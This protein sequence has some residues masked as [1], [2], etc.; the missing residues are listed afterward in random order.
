MSS[1]DHNVGDEEEYKHSCV[2]FL[3]K[4]GIWRKYGGNGLMGSSIF[5]NEKMRALIF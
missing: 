3:R 2:C 5:S 4:Y 1:V